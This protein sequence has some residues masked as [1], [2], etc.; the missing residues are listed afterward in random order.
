MAFNNPKWMF[1]EETKRSANRSQVDLT[2]FALKQTC[3]GGFPERQCDASARSSSPSA[4]TC[5]TEREEASG[6]ERP[7]TFSGTAKGQFIGIFQVPTNRHTQC[8]SAPRGNGIDCI[9]IKEC[10]GRSR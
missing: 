4:Q 10:L 1:D 9:C 8:R 6:V 7:P 3:G 5:V 2:R